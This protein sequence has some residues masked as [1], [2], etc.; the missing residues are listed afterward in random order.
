MQKCQIPKILFDPLFG[1]K[2]IKFVEKGHKGQ[3]KFMVA[4]IE[5]SVK[6]YWRIAKVIRASN[7]SMF[8]EKT[9]NNKGWQRP[10]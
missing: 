2:R 1:W 3:K 5:W 7:W 8:V 6:W 4:R 10:V 9:K